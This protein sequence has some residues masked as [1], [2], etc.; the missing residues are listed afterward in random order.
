[1]WREHLLEKERD[2]TGLRVE[3]M[4]TKS[5]PVNLLSYRSA[6]DETRDHKEMKLSIDLMYGIPADNE[7]NEPTFPEYVN[8]RKQRL[9]KFHD[10]C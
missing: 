2:A 6:Q 5:L 8:D 9:R 1:M 3:L 7:E 10:D 4:V